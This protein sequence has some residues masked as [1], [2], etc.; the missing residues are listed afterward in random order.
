M[1]TELIGICY[2]VHIVHLV[3]L[4]LNIHILNAN[5]IFLQVPTGSMPTLSTLSTKNFMC[6]MS[7]L[8]NLYTMATMST[9][10]CLLWS[11]ITRGTYNSTTTGFCGTLV[12]DSFLVWSRPSLISGTG[13][14]KFLFS[15]P[16]TRPLQ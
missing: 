11:K 6:T 5:H 16:F 8:S 12:P 2:Q 10:T 14:I 1:S 7:M 15:F 13:D 4:V 3:P 9:F